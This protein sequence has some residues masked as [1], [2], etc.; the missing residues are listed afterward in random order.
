MTIGV[1]ENRNELQK[2]ISINLGRTM[3][4]EEKN[5]FDTIIELT[6]GHTLIIELIARQIASGSIS[7]KKALEL[8]K[9]EG[10]THYS[11]DKIGNIKDGEEMYATIS[12][13]VAELFKAGS[14]P[15]HHITALKTL[16]LLSVRGYETQIFCDIMKVINIPDLLILNSQGWTSVDDRVRVHP[17]IAEMA[18]R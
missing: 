17:V 8:I 2:L 15:E 13:I 18:D 5:V 7:I 4:K 3:T 14:M 9:K 6:Q 16:S 10:F 11:N 12:R 1:I